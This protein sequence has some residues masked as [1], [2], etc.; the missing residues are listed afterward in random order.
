M[1]RRYL[2]KSLYARVALIVILPIFLM[3]AVI[4]FAFFNRHWD[5]V[6]ANLSA[7]VAGQIAAVSRLYETAQTQDEQIR[8]IALAADDLKLQVSFESGAKIPDNDELS[9]FNVYNSTLDRR[10]RESLDHPYWFNTRSWPNHI[11][12]RVQLD[13]GLLVILADRERVFATTGPLFLFWLVGTSILLGAIAVVFLRNQVRSILRLAH[14][15]EAF[16]RGRDAPDYRPSGATEVRRAGYAFIAMRERIKRHLEQRTTTLAGVSHDLR[17]PLTRIKLALEMAPPSDDLEDIRKDVNEMEKMVEAYISFA[18]Q[19]AADE[20]PEPFS[21][22]AMIDEIA[23]DT[24]RSGHRINTDVPKHLTIAARRGSLKRAI[25]NLVSNGLR[26]GDNV[27]V[28]LR[29]SDRTIDFMVDDDG[30]GL[31]PEDFD[32]VFKPFLRLDDARNLNE[33]GVG[34]GL[35]IVRDIARAHGGDVTLGRSTHGGLQATMKLPL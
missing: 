22:T 8:V 14:A 35:T 18:R 19:D 31:D 6:S 20:D 16:G 9:I 2:P 26:H 7:N 30:P 15:A 24:A 34:M 17:T 4:T 13:N 11:E 10:L 28:S 25:S 3:Q 23:A 27:W 21:I 33:S 32:R 12:V 29:K 5:L 1:L